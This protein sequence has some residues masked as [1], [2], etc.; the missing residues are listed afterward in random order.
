MGFKL[1]SSHQL[2]SLLDLLSS[3]CVANEACLPDNHPFV[4]VRT[5]DYWSATT[6]GHDLANAWVVQPGNPTLMPQ[7]LLT[8]ASTDKGDTLGVWCVRTGQ[9]GPSAY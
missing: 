9:S 8:V 1:P 7:R 5:D 2:T 6:T 4:G 3:D